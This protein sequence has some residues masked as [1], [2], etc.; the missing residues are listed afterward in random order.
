MKFYNSS[1]SL[2][3]RWELRFCSPNIFMDDQ[4]NPKSD[5]DDELKRLFRRHYWRRASCIDAFAAAL[6]AFWYDKLVSPLNAPCC[7]SAA[8]EP[9]GVMNPAVPAPV[10]PVRHKFVSGRNKLIIKVANWFS[11]IHLPV[12]AAVA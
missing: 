10:A 12:A 2:R 7:G 8:Y 1:L 9:Y 11:V 3:L 6:A 5:N 4:F